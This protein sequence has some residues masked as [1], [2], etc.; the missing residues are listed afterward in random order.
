MFLSG[1]LVGL[2][3][4]EPSDVELLYNWENNLQLWS[5]GLTQTPFSK[6]VLEEFV[7]ASHLD[8][9]TNKQLRLMINTLADEETIGTIDLF[10]FDPTHARAGV[11]IFIHQNH[12]RKGLAEESL[13][14]LKRY[15]FSILHLH[16]LYADVSKKNTASL[17]LFIK[18]GFIQTGI[19]KHW[20]QTATQQFEEVVFL[21][22]IST[23]DQI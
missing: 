22:C 15:C 10:D 23:G 4:M 20:L 18:S 16:Q 17:Q 14:L 8:I 1:E 6:H 5:A 7:N 11:G 2:R 19:K 3:A 21:Q 12:R 9:Y 13:Q